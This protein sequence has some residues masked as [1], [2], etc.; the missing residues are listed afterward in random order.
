MSGGISKMRKRFWPILFPFLLPPTSRYR[1]CLFSNNPLIAC[2]ISF[3]LAPVRWVSS[4]M[5][6]VKRLSPGGKVSATRDLRP[7]IILKSRG[8]KEAIEDSFEIRTIL[9]R[10]SG[11][12]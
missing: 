3:L 10:S 2:L 6:I 1:R 11:Q 12:A 5:L 9:V 7:V 4:S 8:S